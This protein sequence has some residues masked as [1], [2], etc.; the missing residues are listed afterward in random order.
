M[1]LN[2][3]KLNE[4]F[5]KIGK[6][7]WGLL[8]WFSKIILFLFFLITAIIFW[9]NISIQLVQDYQINLSKQIGQMILIVLILIILIGI[10][11][12]KNLRNKK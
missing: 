11:I 12:L 9:Q 10:D 3:Y 2:Q 7:S 6:L 8:I 5:S 1:N 4:K